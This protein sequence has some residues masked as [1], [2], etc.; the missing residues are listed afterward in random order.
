MINN[1]NLKKITYLL[2]TIYFLIGATTFKD[3]GIT[4]D[5][6]FQRSSG[7]YW[8]NYI[9]SFTPFDQLSSAVEL[10]I[11]KIDGF[12]LPGVEGNQFYG[13]IFDLPAAFLEII[14]EV[15]D[16]KNYFHLKHFLNFVLFFA[17]SI[18]FY[19]ILL[20]RFKNPLI[21]LTGTLFFILSPR[22]YGN[23]FFNMKD[24]VSLS[25]LTIS[26]FYCFKLLDKANF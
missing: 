17:A 7:F 9:L 15:E 8:L 1:N 2:F 18:F 5:E 23:S 12:T 11:S 10:K 6:E 26:L 21:A 24:I 3:Y 13:V 19:K 25:L 16:S 20:N 22:I 14:F 4:T